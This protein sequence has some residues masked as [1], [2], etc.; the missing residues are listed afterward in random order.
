MPTASVSLSLHQRS[1]CFSFEFHPDLR[2]FVNKLLRSPRRATSS[3]VLLVTCSVVDLVV[4]PHAS[5]SFQVPWPLSSRPRPQTVATV[6]I[7]TPSS[8]AGPI[9]ADAPAVEIDLEAQDETRDDAPASDRVPFFF[10]WVVASRSG[11]RAR[12]PSLV[13]MQAR[14]TGA[15]LSVNDRPVPRLAGLRLGMAAAVHH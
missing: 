9:Y 10:S 13:E 3:S 11:F 6:P 12:Y 15:A 1:P 7:I 4:L 8:H 14:G 2:Y 5:S